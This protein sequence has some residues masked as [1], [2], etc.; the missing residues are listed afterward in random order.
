[1]KKRGSKFDLIDQTEG[2]QQAKLY[3][4]EF[5]NDQKKKG[6]EKIWQLMESYL[7]NDVNSI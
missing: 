7:G 5:S 3:R 1:M 6:T 4:P 2:N